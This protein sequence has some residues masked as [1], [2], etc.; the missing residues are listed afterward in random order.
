[1]IRVSLPEQRENI[2]GANARL[3]HFSDFP[4]SPT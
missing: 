3:W 1:L 2:V 4:R